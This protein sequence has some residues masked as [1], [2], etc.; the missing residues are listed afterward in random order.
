MKLVLD[1]YIS[2]KITGNAHAKVDVLMDATRFIGHISFLRDYK[3]TMICYTHLGTILK[4]M[5][6]YDRCFFF[7]VSLCMSSC[8]K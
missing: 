2:K 7:L 1:G 6:D 5:S 8:H 4:H 3:F